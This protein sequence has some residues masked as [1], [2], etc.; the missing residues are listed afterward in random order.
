MNEDGI[1][2]INAIRDLLDFVCEHDLEEADRLFCCLTI[3]P[4][5]KEDLISRTRGMGTLEKIVQTIGET[6]TL[7]KKFGQH[8]V[9]ID[10]DIN[11]EKVCERIVTKKLLPAEEER[12][13]PA[14][15]E[16]EVDVVTWKCPES[17]LAGLHDPIEA[18]IEPELVEDI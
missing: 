12:I 1:K 10:F 4:K 16:Q 9:F 13:I 17:L 3:Y 7:R 14:K 5:N 11:R 6:F 15:P 8:G 18:K 2:R